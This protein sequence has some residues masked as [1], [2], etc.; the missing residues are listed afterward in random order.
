MRRAWSSEFTAAVSLAL[1]GLLLSDA[2]RDSGVRFVTGAA[3]LS[4]LVFLT[5]SAGLCQ[6]PDIPRG[7]RIRL[8]VEEDHPLGLV[9]LLE[10]GIEPL[11]RKAGPRRNREP[12]VLEHRV[13][14]LPG[15][16]VRELVRPDDED[17]SSND[18]ARSRSTVRG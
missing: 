11:P 4:L 14:L 5:C 9:E 7:G 15:E 12:G 2:V 3:V 13:R 16:E 10:H 1:G 8:D 6:A 17:G 18:S